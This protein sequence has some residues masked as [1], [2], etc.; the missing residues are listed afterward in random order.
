MIERYTNLFF[1][2]L[3]SD[4]N[5]YQTWFDVEV[6]A[7]KALEKSNKIPKNTT[8]FPSITWDSKRI[9]EIEEECKHDFIA[10]LTFLEEK[11]GPSA[12]FIH[13][14]LTTSDIIDTS[15]SLNLIK[16]LYL[17]SKI[18]HTFFSCACKRIT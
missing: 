9:L 6:A 10:F 7:L 17:L 8:K 3:W 2:N 5:K 4:E 12:K 14:G 11:I 1:K 13:L 16:A 18:F 15:L